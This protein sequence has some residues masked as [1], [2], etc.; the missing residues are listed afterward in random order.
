MPSH[1]TC[2]ISLS[3]IST[4]AR[5]MASMG[6]DEAKNK[7]KENLDYILRPSAT[8]AGQYHLVFVRTDGETFGCMQ[9][10]GDKKFIRELCVKALD[11]RARKHRNI[12]GKTKGVSLCHKVVI[13]LP[14]DANLDHQMGIAQGILDELGG[15]SEA[16]IL[17]AI[18]FDTPGNPHLHLWIVD[19]PE[20]LEAAKARAEE[21]KRAKA[22]S[23]TKKTRVTRRDHLRLTDKDGYKKVRQTIA[24]VIDEIAV[25]KGLRRPEIRSL[26]ERGIEREPQVHEGPEFTQKA[27]LTTDMDELSRSLTLATYSAVTKNVVSI[28]ANNYVLSEY[29][30]T[31]HLD[32]DLEIFPSRLKG[33]ATW[34]LQR[35]NERAAEERSKWPTAIALT[36]KP[37]DYLEDVLVAARV[38]GDESRQVIA[39]LPLSS[40]AE[41]EGLTIYPDQSEVEA[42][43]LAGPSSDKSEAVYA[44][45]DTVAGNT[46]TVCEAPGKETGGDHIPTPLAST[47]EAVFI[48]NSESASPAIEGH[49]DG[50]REEPI[51]PDWAS[52]TI[53]RI[54]TAP[55]PAS[56]ASAGVE[57]GKAPNILSGDHSNALCEIQE[58]ANKEIT[59]T[60]SPSSNSADQVR[61]DTSSVDEAEKSQQQLEPGPNAPAPEQ[62]PSTPTPVA[63]S[64]Q[65]HPALASPVEATMAASEQPG[66]STT[67]KAITLTAPPDTEASTA[68]STDRLLD[69][70]Y[71]DDFGSGWAEF[72]KE[73]WGDDFEKSATTSSPSD[74]IT[75][76]SAVPI[77]RKEPRQNLEE[78]IAVALRQTMRDSKTSTEKEK[79]D[80]VRPGGQGSLEHDG[81]PGETTKRQPSP[82]EMG[83]RTA[84]ATCSKPGRM[85]M[86]SSIEA[87]I[88][89]LR[90]SSP[91][92]PPPPRNKKFGRR[93]RDDER[94]I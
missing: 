26:A 46:S 87:A 55:S 54:Q 59:P 1:Y 43:L 49:H 33:F 47:S 93:R 32:V 67:G 9:D 94:E 79:S 86:T 74:K 45:H 19:G 72:A 37:T 88:R 25:R 39:D 90:K 10:A 28:M 42:F 31:D 58:D 70:D 38:R 80:L 8:R 16:F 18:H 63:E 64:A 23:D 48:D 77:S 57:K 85:R 40:P 50:E 52:W 15:G 3:S 56:A 21:R 76:R 65:R 71:D 62:P 20:T 13:S 84:D 5:S 60:G 78:G 11:K 41:V 83:E 34:T 51:D 69:L 44:E 24:K 82:I 73:E 22:K 12:K 7:A 17:A 14:K 2:H 30:P 29:A 4:D 89:K 6:L 66:N 91:P 75:P 36:D 27:A 68:T 53:E 61:A 92:P 35:I 81:P